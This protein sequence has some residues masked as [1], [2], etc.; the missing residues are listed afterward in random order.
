MFLFLKFIFFYTEL[1]NE[2]FYGK[3]ILPFIFFSFLYK[4]TVV[5][6]TYRH[7]ATAHVL[8]SSVIESL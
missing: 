3:N 1:L 4:E 8:S 5:Q 6:T 7:N 2:T